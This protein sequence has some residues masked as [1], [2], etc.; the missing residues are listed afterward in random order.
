MKIKNDTM[1]TAKPKFQD[2]ITLKLG[3]GFDFQISGKD[4]DGEWRMYNNSAEVL[5][6]DGELKIVYNGTYYTPVTFLTCDFL[7][8]EFYVDYIHVYG[9]IMAFNESRNL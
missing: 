9:N 1:I 8:G 4:E 2:S 5:E 6:Q 7:D 3:D